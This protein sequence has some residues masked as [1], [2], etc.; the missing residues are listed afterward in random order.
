MISEPLGILADIT[1]A[2]VIMFIFPLLCVNAM[3]ERISD[4]YIHGI[5]S[6]FAETVCNK[7][8]IDEELYEAFIARLA[9]TGHCRSVEITERIPRYEPVYESGIFTGEVIE[10]GEVLGTEELLKRIYS[11]DGCKLARGAGLSIEIYDGGLGLVRCS[12][13]VKGRAK[14]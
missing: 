2:I 1:A 4:R 7:G 3:K 9:G 10:F 11:E 12:G 14:R 13:T 5:T 6:Q 8:Y